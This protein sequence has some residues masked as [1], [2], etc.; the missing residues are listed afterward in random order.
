MSVSDP[1]LLLKSQDKWPPGRRRGNTDGNVDPGEQPGR[2]QGKGVRQ[3]TED[4]KPG[5]HRGSREKR[6]RSLECSSGAKALQRDGEQER[7]RRIQAL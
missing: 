1:K 6:I 3:E 7:G 5:G 2:S 4:R